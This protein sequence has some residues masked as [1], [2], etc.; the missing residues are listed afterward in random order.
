M[1]MVGEWGS[2]RSLSFERHGGFIFISLKGNPS[3][4]HC[5]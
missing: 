1:D 4:L 2:P 3:K 5:K